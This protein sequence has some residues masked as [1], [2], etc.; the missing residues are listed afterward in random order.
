MDIM[1]RMEDM[2]RGVSS[3]GM[4][5]G[6]DMGMDMCSRRRVRRIK[7]SERLRRGSR[8]SYRLYRR[9]FSSLVVTSLSV[10]H[11]IRVLSPPTF[12]DRAMTVG[13][14]FCFFSVRC[15]ICTESSLV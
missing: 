5:M 1:M 2:G 7:R 15:G 10:F 8:Q 12:Y 11:I 3:M 6:T 4:D 13:F 14:L 9:W